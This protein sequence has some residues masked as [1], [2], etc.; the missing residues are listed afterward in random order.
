MSYRVHE[1]A[2]KFG[3]AA[4]YT[5][6]QAFGG[7]VAEKPFDPIEPRGRGRG[8]MHMEARMSRE[9]PP[10]LGM[11]MCGLIV[12]NQMQGFLLGGFPIDLAPEAQPFL[13]TVAII[14]AT[15][16]SSVFSAAKS[17]VVP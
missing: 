2:D 8:E 15:A 13:V 10:D 9:P 1:G 4:E 5:A 11:L 7:D 16:P 12:A 3:E 17:V 6:A 14:T